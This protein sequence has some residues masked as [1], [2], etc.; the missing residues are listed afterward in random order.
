MGKG[1]NV[2]YVSIQM[3]PEEKATLDAAVERSG[4]RRNRFLRDLIATLRPK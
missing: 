2:V 4:K 3:S 1:P